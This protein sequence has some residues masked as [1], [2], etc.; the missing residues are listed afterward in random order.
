M[1]EWDN[2]HQSGD[3]KKTTNMTIKEALLYIEAY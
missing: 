1:G 2:S 3:C